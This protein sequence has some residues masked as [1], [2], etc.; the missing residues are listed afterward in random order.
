MLRTHIYNSELQSLY[1]ENR[2]THTVKEMEKNHE[3]KPN[4]DS[5]ASL[6]SKNQGYQSNNSNHILNV[7]YTQPLNE[8]SVKISS[9]SEMMNELTNNNKITIPL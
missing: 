2:K 8:S 9:C 6:C 5:I 1:H 3:M 7:G 4:M